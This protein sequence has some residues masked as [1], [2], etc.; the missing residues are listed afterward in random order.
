M[1]AFSGGAVA[2]PDLPDFSAPRGQ[3]GSDKLT[4]Q[5]WVSHETVAP[6]GEFRLLL[7]AEIAEDWV[8]YSPDIVGIGESLKLIVRTS[9]EIPVGEILYARD[10]PKKQ[11]LGGQTVVNWSYED[12]AYFLIPL[13]VPDDIDVEAIAVTVVPYGQVC[14]GPNDSCVNIQSPVAE[15]EVVAA[16]LNVDVGERAELSEQWRQNEAEFESIIADLLTLDEL[17]AFHSEQETQG[18][19]ASQAVFV[20][21]TDPTD[22][23]FWA[24]LGVALLAGLTLNIMPCVLPVIPI[25]ILGIVETAGHSRRRFVTLGLGFAAGVF[26]FF[27]GVAILSVALKITVGRAFNLNE[28]FQYPAGIIVLAGIVAA[29]AANLFGVFNVVVPGKVAGAEEAVQS[30]RGHARAFGMGF[31]LAVLATPCS[32]AFLVAALTYAQA[33]PLV[34]GTAVILAIGLGM[35]A[36]HALLVA[37]PQLVDKLPRPGRW[38]E[39]FKQGSGFVLLL[40]A[41]WL[42]STLRGG[43]GSYPFWVVAWMV[44]MVMGLWMWASW[45]RYDAPLRSKLI[46]RLIAVALVAATGAAML[47]PPEPSLLKARDFDAAEIADTRQENIV[48]VKFTANWCIKCLQQEE[49]VFE[50]PRIAEAFEE[51]G[52]VYFKGDTSRKSM[53]AA[54]WMWEKGYGAAVPLTLVYPPGQGAPLAAH[55]LDEQKMLKMLRQ[56]SSGGN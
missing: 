44:L 56:A 54:R 2:Q 14:G 49:E 33:A 30:S 4:W 10:F 43:G 20:G 47:R 38:M 23:S 8:L 5:A 7:K 45:L 32:F 42:V 18:S 51:Y 46:V 1:L 39:L 48:V 34:L 50:S 35:A 40:V 6:G 21:E 9:P 15:E 29:L 52:V 13:K 36:P 17:K 22:L 26:A 37:F 11:N 24:A 55:D 16:E 27:L 3:I 41:V 28:L 31:M 53:P 25:R 12:E 19:A